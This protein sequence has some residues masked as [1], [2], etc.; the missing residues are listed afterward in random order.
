MREAEKIAAPSMQAA[1]YRAA[2]S[3]D[4]PSRQMICKQSR[5]QA[6]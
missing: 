2:T 1:R 4:E 5:C 6:R 3:I